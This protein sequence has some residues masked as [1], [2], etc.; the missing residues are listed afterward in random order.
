MKVAATTTHEE[1]AAQLAATTGETHAV[2]EQA[3][4]PS[5]IAGGLQALGLDGKL[6][7]AQLINFFILF[8]LLRKFLYGPLVGLLEKRRLQ[9]EQSVKQAEEIEQQHA[10]FTVEHQKRLEKAKAEAAAIVNEAKQ[11]ADALRQEQLAATQTET[12]KMLR[13]AK[14]DIGRQKEQLLDE[15]KQE[16]GALVVTTTAKVIGKHLDRD[17]E[18]RLLKEAINE[19]KR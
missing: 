16:V 7:A 9:I 2:V 14:E 18:E 5:G 3:V 13:Q 12:D 8:F 1:S 19:V 11:A 10:E 15:L 6:L 4:Q 17:A